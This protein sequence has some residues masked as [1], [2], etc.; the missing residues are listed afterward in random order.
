ML[1]KIVLLTLVHSLRSYRLYLLY[2]ST[3]RNERRNWGQ[4]H[5]RFRASGNTNQSL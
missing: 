5:V 3:V 2:F 4:L 1:L